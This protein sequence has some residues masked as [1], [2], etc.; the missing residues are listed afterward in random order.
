MNRSMA[1]LSRILFSGDTEM[2]GV[3]QAVYPATGRAHVATRL[4]LMD[5]SYTETVEVGQK[6]LVSRGGIRPSPVQVQ[7]G[8]YWV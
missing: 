2:P 4:G 8:V 7:D 3:V 5:C 1:A 6:V